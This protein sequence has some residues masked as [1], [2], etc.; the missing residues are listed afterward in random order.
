VTRLFAAGI[1]LLGICAVIVS[2]GPV[3]AATLSSFSDLISTS[4]PSAGA[5]HTL[6]FTTTGAIPASGHIVIT[7]H[8]GAF[9]I[10]AGF[11]YTDVD[12]A[13]SSGGPFTD[14]DLAAS[15][16]AAN[17]GVAVTTGS[18]GSITITL[19]S[20]T[21]IS[22]GDIVRVRLGTIATYGVAGN[23]S[24]TNPAT[25]ASYRVGILTSNAASTQIDTGT[26]MIAVVDQVTVTAEPEAVAPTRSNG[27]PSG[28]LAAGNSTIELTLSTDIAATCRYATSSAVAY[29]SMT[30][31]FTSYGTNSFKTV[32]TGHQNNTTYSYY[33]RCLSNVGVP[34]LDDYVI[35]FSLDIDP[36]SN[37]SVEPGPFLGRGGEGEFRHGSET[38]YQSSVTM[39]GWA[40]PVSAVTLL[41]DGKIA[42]RTTT[43]AD[44]SFSATISGIERGTYTFQAYF[45]DGTGARSSS[46]TSTLSLGSG[47]NNT[48]SNIVIPPTIV[49]SSESIGVGESTV[50]SGSSALKGSIELST[51][52]QGG[53]TAGIQT[54]SATTSQTGGW[55]ISI[56]SSKLQKGTYI[57]RARVVL[58]SQ[59][60]SDLSKPYY[61]GVGQS[62]SPNLSEGADVNGDKKVNLIDFSIMLTNWGSDDQASDINQ[63]GI[64]NLADFSI[65]LFNW[66]G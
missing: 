29:G 55:R 32:V 52:L 45:E 57:V 26:A 56:P 22:A 43:N 39:S 49:L 40:A 19:N 33:V 24:I 34:N 15:A 60:K 31:S 10:P 58:N 1:S 18:S 42:A 4:A 47:T 66:T 48:I 64:V 23:V 20:A 37:S 61:L 3:Y 28:T 36:I 30:E 2:G 27:L 13:V 12:L 51:Q 63:D 6:Q 8:A 44:G 53:G 59:T 62:P 9:N 25:V 5:S 46:Y 41:K 21:G 17:D 16:S 54:Y 50:V 7:P 35:T 38:L 14:R 65:L 11:D